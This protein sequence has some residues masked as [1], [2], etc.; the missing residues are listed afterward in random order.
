[1]RV[2]KDFLGGREIPDDA[3]YGLQSL[4]AKENFALSYRPVH[5]KLLRAFVLVKKAA[6]VTYQKLAGREGGGRDEIYRAIAAACDALLEREESF[7][8]SDLF[9]TCALQ[10]GAGTS[11]NINVNEVLANLA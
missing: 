6:A 8:S 11:I 10:G 4:R 9:V 5:P 1:M 3:L 2:E 7:S